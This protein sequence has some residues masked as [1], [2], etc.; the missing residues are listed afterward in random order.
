VAP[1]RRRAS[2]R[3]RVEGALVR[4]IT[5]GELEPGV[6]YSAS[7]LAA[8]FDVSAT[9]VREA[10]INLEQRGLIEAVH[11]RGFR[12]TVLSEE[13]LDEIVQ[14]RLLLEPPTMRRIA[15]CLPPRDQ[16]RLRALADRVLTA[17]Q[18]GELSAYLSAD[19]DFHTALT[20]C[21]GN[22]RLTDLVT[23]LR[24]QTRPLQ[25]PRPVDAEALADAAREHHELLRQLAAGDGA[26]AERLMSAHLRR[27]LGP[28]PEPVR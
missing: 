17:A 8:R 3:Q 1:I 10:M 11:S 16:A 2:L 28:E 13:A 24:E 14:I 22:D 15:G 9:P 7:S 25:P 6:L 5:V 23:E 21:A 27:V 12:V 4:A 20:A 26:G 19:A 18:G